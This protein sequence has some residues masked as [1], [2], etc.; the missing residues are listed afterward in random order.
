MTHNY[1]VKTFIESIHYNLTNKW[2]VSG[3]CI[4]L[5]SRRVLT[6]QVNEKCY[7]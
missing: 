6:V 3:M 2:W 1:E 4:Y 7:N 5:H